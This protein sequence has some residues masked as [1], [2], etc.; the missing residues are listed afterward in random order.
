MAT[1]DALVQELD[2]LNHMNGVSAVDILELPAELQ[3]VLQSML[4][5][6]MSLAQLASELQLS[7][8]EA[9]IVADM[10]VEKGFLISEER[11][12]SGGPRYKVYF[13]RTH[14]HHI[15]AEL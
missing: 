6:P 15:P 11:G 7:E 14:T 1:F 8:D 13:A 9:R 3:S 2:R 5:R 4:R 10:L 12:E